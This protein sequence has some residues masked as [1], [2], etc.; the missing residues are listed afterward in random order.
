VKKKRIPTASLF[1]AVVL[2][3]L[4]VEVAPA[5]ATVTINTI[6]FV[7]PDADTMDDYDG[8]HLSR[9]AAPVDARTTDVHVN[10]LDCSEDRGLGFVIG[11][12]IT[13]S[14]PGTNLKVLIGD[15]TLTCTDPVQM[16][17]CRSVYEQPA[18]TST[19]TLPPIGAG[20]DVV[21]DTTCP[22]TTGNLKLW[23]IIEVSGAPQAGE[24]TR[25]INF[26][27]D[28]PEPPLDLAAAPGESS[29][30]LTFTSN[31]ANTVMVDEWRYL[32]G[33]APGGTSPGDAGTGTDA[34]AG[35]TDAG[36]GTD[37]GTVAANGLY[38]A[39]PAGFSPCM[40]IEP[41]SDPAFD[42]F[43]M[44]PLGGSVR[45]Q[46]I[47]DGSAASMLVNDTPYDVSL[48]VIDNYL[49]ASAPVFAENVVPV[50]TD[51]FAETYGSAGGRESGG[52]CGV[53]G[54]RPGG[55]GG[56]GTAARV[57]GA[58][59]ALGLA[60]ALVRWRRRRGGTGGAGAG[61]GTV[62]VAVA[63]AGALWLLLG[64]T[65]RAAEPSSGDRPTSEGGLELAAGPDVEVD[66]ESPQRFAFELKFGPYLPDVDKEFS[67][68]GVAPFAAHFGRRDRDTGELLYHKNGK[69]KVPAR[70]LARLELDWQLLRFPG[71]TLSP[72]A[73]IGFWN[74]VGVAFAQD[75]TG[76]VPPLDRI[77]TEDKTALILWPWAV[78]AVLRLDYGARNWNIPVVP[79][80]KLAFD[81]T[82]YWIKSSTG[83][84]AEFPGGGKAR[85]GIPGW[86]VDFG[87]MLLLDF[88]D[89]G[90]TARFD[91]SWGVNNSYVFFEWS[92]AQVDGFGRRMILSDSTWSVGLALEY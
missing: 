86:E 7:D 55:G 62:A 4:L 50:P 17:S 48:Q 40:Q 3:G 72:Y 1:A 59:L 14:N 60:A 37:A 21:G 91:E 24:K 25:A 28:P 43:Y 87:G 15:T 71:G 52:Y 42:E 74:A 19:V 49:N 67:G 56:A 84:I 63:T 5:F 80:V 69:P 64:G 6:T 47:W 82:F 88:F 29:V 36:A 34:A 54:G 85:G 46:W 89:P 78:G 16:A 57:G 39:P 45:L 68:K 12:T 79:F 53:T 58:L 26:D 27:L 9:I 35:G 76:T 61:V 51:D 32:A 73:S 20:S 41:S 44:D 8:G 38:P 22:G 83:T 18:T 11:M 31:P 30:T 23:A 66:E 13:G 77:P 81:Y 92:Y 90:A 65:A 75:E 33:C 70:P 2:S 10:L